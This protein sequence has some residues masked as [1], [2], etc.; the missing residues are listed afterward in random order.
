MSTPGFIKRWFGYSR[1][2]RSGT[3][4]LS[5]IL[6]IVVVARAFLLANSRKSEPGN[7][8]IIEE[9]GLPYDSTGAFTSNDY[10]VA[11]PLLKKFD[12]NISTVDELISLGLSDKQANTLNNYR[13]S[14]GIFRSPEDFRKIYGISPALAD[15]LI[16]YIEINRHQPVQAAARQK[17]GE[18]RDMDN[19][20]DGNSFTGEE[21]MVI[22]HTLIELNSADSGRL[23]ILRGIGPVLSSRIIKYR[24]LLGGFVSASQLGEVYGIDSSLVMSLSGYLEVDTSLLVKIDL[25]RAGYGELIRHPY[26][27]KEQTG[28]ILRYRSLAGEFSS[29]GQLLINRIFSEEEYRRLKPYLSVSCSNEE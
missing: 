10:S 26:I 2:E 27:T 25:N 23:V 28:M 15:M 1:R 9:A 24:S 5:I 4:F 14:G 17:G 19:M 7:P 11:E 29:P 6:V 18:S 13:L 3:L 20:G 21:A 22:N 16:P 12:P 8:V